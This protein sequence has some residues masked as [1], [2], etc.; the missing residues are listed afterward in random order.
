METIG[1]KCSSN[2]FTQFLNHAFSK[3]FLQAKKLFLNSFDIFMN[4]SL[5]RF[6]IVLHSK[7]CEINVEAVGALKG[8][9]EFQKLLY[10][11]TNLKR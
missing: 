8:K 3:F 6:Q 4:F 9:R 1:I 10:R 2:P 5:S 11:I 7:L